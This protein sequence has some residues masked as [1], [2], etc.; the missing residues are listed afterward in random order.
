MKIKICHI[1]D[2][3]T[4][5]SDG[6][7][8]HLLMLL[9][10]IDKNRFEQIVI[11]QGGELVENELIK[12]NIYRFIVPELKKRF[13]FKAFI[14][15]YKILMNEEVDIIQTH[16]LKPY[17]I[18]GLMNIFLRKKLV[19]NYNGLFISSVYHNPLERL[20]LQIIHIII[21]SSG[22]VQLAIVPSQNSK[23]ILEAETK[24][25]PR[26]DIYYNGFSLSL[27]DTSDERIINKLQELKKE[28]FVVGIVARIEIQ[29]RIDSALN[30]LKKLKS[31]DKNVFFVFFGDGPLEKEMIHLSNSLGIMDRLQFLGYVENAKNYIRYLDTILFT[32]DW[33]GFPLTIWEAMAAG[34]PII[35]SDV[36]GI[37]EI[38]EK[39]KCGLIYPKEDS[40]KAIKS[41]IELMNNN[42][43]RMELGENGKKAIK[44][45][46]NLENFVQFFENLYTN[47]I[48]K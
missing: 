31:L 46:Y 24:I 4:G 41:I 42:S 30:I 40:E 20:V 48:I 14:K 29:K 37:K 39:E 11:Y 36:G 35:S 17:I 23:R 21:V 16:L 5:Q 9:N 38:L 25:F 6:V 2:R 44:G 10:N 1:C 43:Y 15:I 47:L 19:F 3:I 32:S 27:V 13:S 8:T 22:S 12:N 33:E 18:C 26:V 34:V 7:Y 28:F 45:K